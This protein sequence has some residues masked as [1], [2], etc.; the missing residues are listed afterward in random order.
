METNGAML[1]KTPSKKTEL[2]RRELVI[3]DNL[4]D[5]FDEGFHFCS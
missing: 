5:F 4:E 3:H 1:N 2:N